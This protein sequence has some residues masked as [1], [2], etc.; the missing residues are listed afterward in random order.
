MSRKL[1]E[2]E[3]KLYRNFDNLDLLII[4]DVEPDESHVRKP[5][6]PLETIQN[7]YE[8]LTKLKKDLDA[9]GKLNWVPIDAN[10]DLDQVYLEI[11]RA[12]W[13]IL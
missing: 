12:V 7:K 1:S 9:E 2:R 6:H 8:A 3:K 13:A 4:L 11:R 5:D 10:M